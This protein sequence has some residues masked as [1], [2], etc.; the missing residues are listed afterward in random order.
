MEQILATRTAA[1]SRVWESEGKPAGSAMFGNTEQ[2][3]NLGILTRMVIRSNP[4][5]KHGTLQNITEQ[6]KPACL[7]RLQN[8]PLQPACLGPL[9]APP[10]TTRMF[11]R[12][13]ISPAVP[14]TPLQAK[15]DASFQRFQ[16]SSSWSHSTNIVHPISIK[17]RTPLF[18]NLTPLGK[19][20]APWVP[21]YKPPW[22]PRLPID[23]TMRMEYNG[24]NKWEI[25]SRCR[26]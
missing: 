4:V 17:K 11:A 16:K 15:P 12:F 14:V 21:I 13:P 8:A 7:G 9:R 5:L 18:F 10:A 22:V 26:G 20:W 25:P 6:P 19:I 1:F 3:A 24:I 2:S 23:I